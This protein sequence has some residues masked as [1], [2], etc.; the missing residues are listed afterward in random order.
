MQD[1]EYIPHGEDIEA[2]LKR[3]IAKPIIRWED[4]PQLGYEILPNKYFYRYQPPTP[5]K[6]LL[7]EFWKLEKEAEKMLGG[8]RNERYHDDILR[9]LPNG[10]TF[11]RLKDVVS[12]RNEKTY[13]AT[14]DEDYLELEDMESGTGRILSRRNTLEVESAVTIFRK[15][16]ILF[17]KLRPYLEKYYEAIL[18]GKCTGEIV[19]FKP[20]R[21]AGRFSFTFHSFV[22][23]YR[24]LQRSCLRQRRCLALVG[25]TTAF[26]FDVPFRR[27]RNKSDCGLSGCELRSD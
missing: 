2:F 27:C 8:W 4:S 10:W 24:A 11:D 26:Q 25:R 9:T 13:E 14:A 15:G 21:I 20:E 1:D 19:A 5:A 22:M 7:A 23:V 16:D 17:G 12:L 6:D 3:E 18:T